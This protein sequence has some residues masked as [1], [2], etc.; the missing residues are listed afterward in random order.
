MEEVNRYLKIRDIGIKAILW[1]INIMVMECYNKRIAHIL[2]N[3]KKDSM[4]DKVQ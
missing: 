1:M 2:D 3:L 4:M